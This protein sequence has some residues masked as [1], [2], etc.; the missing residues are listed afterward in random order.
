MFDD[1]QPWR[2]T[3]YA[4][5][6]TLGSRNVTAGIFIQTPRGEYRIKNI[7]VYLQN[8]FAKNFVDFLYCYIT[9][10]MN[11]DKFIEFI[12]D[13]LKISF[14]YWVGHNDMIQWHIIC[15]GFLGVIHGMG[16]PVSIFSFLI[17]SLM[18]P[19]LTQSYNL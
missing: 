17:Y 13:F 4:K 2:K 16:F 1:W 18:G 7:F 11:S 12:T 6:E 9:C 5:E 14:F 8:N 15:V 19:L 3:L 10:Y